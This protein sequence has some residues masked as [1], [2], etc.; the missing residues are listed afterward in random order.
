MVEFL[1]SACANQ[2]SD[3][4]AESQQALGVVPC[5]MYKDPHLIVQLALEVKKQRKQTFCMLPFCHTLEAEMLGG[6]INLGDET[7]GARAGSPIC[8]SVADVLNLSVSEAS[9]L[10]FCNMLE[11]CRLL[12]QQGEQVMFCITGPVSVLSCLVEPRAMFKEWRK[13]PSTVNEVLAFLSSLL[14]DVACKAA[15]AG[16][17]AIEYADPPS[18][19]SIVGPK[20]ASALYVGFTRPFV[21]KLSKQLPTGVVL[22]VC[23]LSVAKGTDGLQELPLVATCPK[24]IKSL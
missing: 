18:A 2:K 16:A 5:E 12:V 3:M 7:A 21:E 22:Y 6:N 9:C 14:I 10:R 4:V 1:L 15:R 23:P 19:T 24:A 11:A 8:A 17:C 20:F 13:N